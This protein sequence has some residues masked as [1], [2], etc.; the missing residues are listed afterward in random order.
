MEDYRAAIGS[1]ACLGPGTD[2]QPRYQ[3]SRC[4]RYVTGNGHHSAAGPSGQIPQLAYLELTTTPSPIISH[5]I[6]HSAKA[7]HSAME[8]PRTVL[9]APAH[10]IFLPTPLTARWPSRYYCSR[11]DSDGV[12][13]TGDGRHDLGYR[14]RIWLFRGFI[15]IVQ[16]VQ[17]AGVARVGERALEARKPAGPDKSTGHIW[18]T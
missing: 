9:I 6:P 3:W 12:S 7:K 1:L 11:I 4:A 5:A 8:V 17:L 2:A 16:A 15:V 13:G 18:S 14:D 10:I